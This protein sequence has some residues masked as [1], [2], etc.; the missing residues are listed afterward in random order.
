VSDRQSELD[1]VQ[2]QIAALPKPK[3]PVIDANVAADEAQRAVAL[4]G[5]LGGRISWDGVLRDVSLVLPGNISL[6]RLEAQLPA[7]LPAGT[8]APVPAP[9][10]VPTA[11]VAPTGVSIEGYTKNQRSVA[12]LLARLRTVPSLTNVQLESS[13]REL[14]GKKSI[15]RFIVLADIKQPGGAQ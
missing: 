12:T 6:T 3:R 8:T 13:A 2:A 5:V 4:A 7:P 15:V 1:A 9:T 10:T 11:P 14:V